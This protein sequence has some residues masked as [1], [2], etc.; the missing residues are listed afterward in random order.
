M[1]LTDLEPLFDGSRGELCWPVGRSKTE[2]RSAYADMLPGDPVLLWTGQGRDPQWGVLGT[3]TVSRVSADH[4]TLSRGQR[5]SKP[6][7]PYPK[8]EPA[9]TD[10]VRF[11][12]RVLGEHF[13][14]IGDV[15]QA[16]YGEGRTNPVTVAQVP[17]PSFQEIVAFATS[18]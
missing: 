5:F 7:T 12:V 10:T 15:R 6:V 11:L 9:D 1:R 14:P 17:E 8:G 2:P 13:K 16:V 3:A 18:R 4:L